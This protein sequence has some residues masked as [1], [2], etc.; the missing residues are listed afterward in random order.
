MHVFLYCKLLLSFDLV[1]KGTV[2]FYANKQHLND[3][4]GVEIWIRVVGRAIHPNQDSRRGRK[5]SISVQFSC[6]L[7]FYF[8][9]L[10]FFHSS[11]SNVCKLNFLQLV[12][13]V[14]VVF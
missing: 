3:Q 13:K 10:S 7:H 11:H 8:R 6:L 14:F 5:L 9:F 12:M 4:N 2:Y 1:L